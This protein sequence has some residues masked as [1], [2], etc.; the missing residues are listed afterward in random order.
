MFDI[1]EYAES[2]HNTAIELGLDHKQLHELAH[3]TTDAFNNQELEFDAAVLHD[4]IVYGARFVS[5][6]C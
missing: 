5:G 4:T 2:L 6:I 1:L 3:S